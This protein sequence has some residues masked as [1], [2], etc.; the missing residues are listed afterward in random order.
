MP[1]FFRVHG[2]ARSWDTVSNPLAS[3]D[4]VLVFVRAHAG[5]GTVTAIDAPLIIPN[6]T[7]MRECERPVGKRYGARDASCHTTN[8]T[9]YP[10]AGSVRLAE[11]LAAAGHAHAPSVTSHGATQIIAEVYPH[12]AM[13]A[14]FDLPKT[15]KYKP[16]WGVSQQR[17]GLEILRGY[18]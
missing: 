4:A 6:Q 7:G 16:K 11:T 2:Q 14:L 15:I 9:K 10:D 13:V 5:D 3:T 1:S 17:I 8:L 18:L 12:P